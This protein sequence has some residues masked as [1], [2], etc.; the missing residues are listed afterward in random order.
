MDQTIHLHLSRLQSAWQQTSSVKGQEVLL[1]GWAGCKRQALQR[2]C[3]SGKAVTDN[4]EVKEHG[5]VPIKCCFQT[6]KF[7]FH[8][9]FTQEVLFLWLF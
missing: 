1:L 7:E 3:S 6:L 9:H 8:M 5:R 2:C 4:P